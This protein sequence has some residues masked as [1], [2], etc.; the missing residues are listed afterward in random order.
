[1]FQNRYYSMYFIFSKFDYN[2]FIK[3]VVINYII[4]FFRSVL[5]P[6]LQNPGIREQGD[7]SPQV[8]LCFKFFYHS[9]YLFR[10][11]IFMYNISCLG[12]TLV[13]SKIICLLF[14]V[15]KSWLYL[16][17]TKF[18]GFIHHRQRPSESVGHICCSE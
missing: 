9:E 2:F 1:V 16:G 17:F 13:N 7:F 4:L 6:R 18:L 11:L 14:A 8:S 12:A 3:D 10:P 15:R 5:T